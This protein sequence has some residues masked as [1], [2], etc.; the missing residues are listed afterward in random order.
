MVCDVN[1]GN[2]GHLGNNGAR[3]SI[4]A[5]AKR[6]GKETIGHGHGFCIV[7]GAWMSG[8]SGYLYMGYNNGGS[9]WNHTHIVLYNNGKRAGITI[10][11]G[12]WRAEELR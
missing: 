9:N 2:H 6:G 12:T 11:N 8:V 7:D 10:V 1:N 5:Y 3:G 4:G